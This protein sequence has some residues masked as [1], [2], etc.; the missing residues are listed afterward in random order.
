MGDKGF[1]ELLNE[2]L[3]RFTLTGSTHPPLPSPSMIP[4]SSSL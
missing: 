1:G 3:R 2:R 4:V